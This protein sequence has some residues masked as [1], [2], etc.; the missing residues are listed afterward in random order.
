MD[1][2]NL[3]SAP[4]LKTSLRDIQAGQRTLLTRQSRPS[5]T[6]LEDKENYDNSRSQSKRRSNKYRRRGA[7]LK[8]SI[9][10]RSLENTNSRDIR[11]T[12]T[13]SND[14]DDAETIYSEATE[15]INN[16]DYD[17]K[18]V[19]PT[20]DEEEEQYPVST[21]TKVKTAVVIITTI[22]AVGAYCVAFSESIVMAGGSVAGGV[23]GGYYNNLV[24]LGI[25]AGVCVVVTPV[26][27]LNEWKLIRYPGE[28]EMLL[29]L[30]IQCKDL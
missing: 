12:A 13:G 20:D 8:R 25:A 28:C 21:L 4:L 11:N 6:Q 2:D 9:R 19:L 1:E 29:L 7:L 23:V 17:S 18:N 27:W 5:S 14:V 30:I 10:R 24:V 15:R 16:V 3:L 26:V 22:V